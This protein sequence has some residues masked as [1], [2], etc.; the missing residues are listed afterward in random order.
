MKEEFN[1]DKKGLRKKKSNR[2][3]GTTKFFE[4][5]EEHH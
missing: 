1:K 4:T 5:N 3:T 2:N